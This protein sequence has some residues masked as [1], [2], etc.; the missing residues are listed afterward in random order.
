MKELYWYS[1]PLSW[2]NYEYHAV[3]GDE[4]FHACCIVRNHKLELVVNAAVLCPLQRG[5]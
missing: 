5:W 2:Y 3:Q 1:C 4:T